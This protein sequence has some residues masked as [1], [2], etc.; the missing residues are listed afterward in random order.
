MA[1]EGRRWLVPIGSGFSALSDSYVGMYRRDAARMPGYSRLTGAA[2][3]APT[4]RTLER[5]LKQ[6]ALLF[7][8]RAGN[9][10]PSLTWLF[11]DAISGFGWLQTFEFRLGR[12]NSQN[13]SSGS[14]TEIPYQF[15]TSGSM[16]IAD[17]ELRS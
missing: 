7:F 2:F 8:A 9:G 13:V 10:E 16:R 1:D 6:R 15:G 5:P 4:G 11:K 12:D 17:L 14:E 3:F